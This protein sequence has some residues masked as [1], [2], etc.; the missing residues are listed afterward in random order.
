MSE[1]TLKDVELLINSGK[2][3]E[4]DLRVLEA[5]LTKLEKLKERELFQVR[6]IK[7]VEKVWPTFISGDTTREWPKR[8]SG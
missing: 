2:L 3:S 6:F 7:F 5:Q 8:L 1:I 4:T